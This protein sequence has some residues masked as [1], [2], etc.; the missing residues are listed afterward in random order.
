M[1]TL[2]SRKEIL[3]K[4]TVRTYVKTAEPVGSSSLA[5]ASGLD[6][7][8]ATI[9]NEL[10]ELEEL[11]YLTHPHT[12]AGRIPTEMGYRYYVDHFLERKAPAHETLAPI[13]EAIRE[14]DE[15]AD[16][17]RRAARALSELSGETVLVGFD[18]R[19]VYYTGISNL[20]SKP[21]FRAVGYVTTMS[22]VLDHLDEVMLKVFPSIADEPRVVL[23]E[24]NPFGRECGA[25][26]TRAPF[27]GGYGVLAILGPMRMDYDNDWS[28][29][30]G[31]VTVLKAG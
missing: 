24:S 28:L 7:S 30:T 20:F 1:E 17:L 3:L 22:K 27:A 4:L 21:E 9:R 31:T 29:L 11:G 6:V 26:M 15:D 8:S 13:A 23:G 2:D 5:E 25:I 19:N 16:R 12:S 18:A 10:S 14:A